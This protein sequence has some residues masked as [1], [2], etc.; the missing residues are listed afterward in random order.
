MELSNI[1]KQNQFNKIA[2]VADHRGEEYIKFVI[3]A[4][5]EIGVEHVLPEY[6]KSQTNDYPD[7]VLAANKLYQSKSVDGLILLCGTGVG[8]NVAANKCKG[9]RCVLANDEA[10]AAFGRIHEDC[11]ALAM[12][13]KYADQEKGLEIR[14]CKRKMQRIVKAFVTTKF[15][16][17]RHQRRIDKLNNMK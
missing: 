1:K 4:L 17:G 10:T 2:I 5:D 11:N 6:E 12:P 16:G 8:M 9:I 3:K 14:L 15:D 7:A 13:T